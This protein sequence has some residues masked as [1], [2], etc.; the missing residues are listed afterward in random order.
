M[1][2]YDFTNSNSL[3]M[4]FNDDRGMAESWRTMGYEDYSN[5]NQM[6]MLP[7]M[8]DLTSP[9]TFMFI[10][11]GLGLGIFAQKKFKLMK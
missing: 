8:S 7:T 1:D 2:T 9:K 3:D 4:S 6:G 10:A 11:L 5:H